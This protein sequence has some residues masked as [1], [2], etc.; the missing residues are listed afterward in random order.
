MIAIEGVSRSGV[1]G[2]LAELFIRPPDAELV[3]ALL[4]D[5]GPEEV[6]LLGAEFTEAFRGL[7]RE[8]PPPPYES[9]YREGVLFG[10]TTRK[11]LE[12]FRSFDVEP[13]TTYEGEPPDHIAFE[14]DFM[15]HLCALE[16]GAAGTDELRP[17]LEA[18][19]T[20]LRDHPMAWIGD[21]QREM[22]SMEDAPFYSEL[23]S[24]TSEW[25]AS[26][27]ERLTSMLGHE[28]GSE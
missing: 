19:R 18:E 8:S 2:M 6:D 17:L 27:L 11:V 14:L 12:A 22:E 3:G 24:F 16:E 28:G 25:M 7:R 1:Y 15:R 21:L 9:V 10:E 5:A 4:P 20:F 26:D 13:R 23:V